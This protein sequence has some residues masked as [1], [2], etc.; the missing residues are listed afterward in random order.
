MEKKQKIVQQRI[1]IIAAVACV[2][3]LLASVL[4]LRYAIDENKRETQE[5][6]Q[7]VAQQS[8][9]AVD[10]Q[11][12]GDFQTLEGIAGI[13]GAMDNLD[14]EALLPVINDI[15][16]ENAFIRMGFTDRSGLTDGV[17][18]DG[19]VYKDIDL[20]DKGFVERAYAGEEV[21]TKTQWAETN[22]FWVNYYAVPIWHNGEVAKVLCAVNNSGAFSEI[23]DTSM[24]DGKGYAS[25]IDED[26]NYIIR[27]NHPSLDQD[28]D[29]LNLFELY[30]FSTEEKD[31]M[32]TDFEQG[33]SGFVEYT[34]RGIRMWASYTPLEVNGW[35]IFSVVPEAEINET[36]TMMTW[37]LVGIIVGAILV[38]VFLMVL[39]KRTNDKGIRALRKMAFTDQLT[40]YRNYPKFLIDVRKMLGRKRDKV[41]S[42]W[43]SDLKNF[44]TVNAMF[45]YDVGDR[46]LKFWAGLIESDMREGETFCRVSGD[47]FV[48]LREYISQEESLRRF[49]WIVSSLEAFPDTAKRGYKLEMCSG[50]YVIGEDD[51]DMTIND[52]MD[53]ANVAQKSVKN[54]SGARVA[55]YSAEMHKKIVREAEMEAR[56]ESALLNGEFQVYMQPKI[57]IQH[58][59]TIAGA[60]ALVR[61]ISPKDG[62]LAPGEFIPLFERNGFVIRLDEYMFESVCRMYRERLDGGLKMPV[63][64]SVNVSR[65]CMLQ[66]GFVERYIG[67]KNQYRIPDRCIE[68]EFTESIAF[69]NHALFRSIVKEFQENGF[70]CSLDDFGAGHS[71]LNILKDLPMDVLK[72]D[73][74][75]F[76]E[77]E[78]AHRARE[79]VKGIVNM[80]KALHMK[81]VAEGVES[82]EQVEFLRR[83]GCDV[84]QGYVFSK[85]LPIAE[86]D[87]FVALCEKREENQ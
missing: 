23:M 63:V 2:A 36:F 28:R 11:V 83:I 71:S 21:L 87:D 80:A 85:P 25:I 14:F 10:K 44:K 7:E 3:F 70:L 40:G 64:I 82:L 46:I 73:M 27:S 33:E 9:L 59:D 38:F 75:F 81:T 41:Y 57:D 67:I 20:K 42:L 62:F 24:F 6:M 54:L 45:G 19:T 74:L 65:L 86:F 8:K 1:Y 66:P 47:N 53:A 13:L 50:I 79:V 43:Y 49:H 17:D 55:F 61:W 26:G 4:F 77:G 12:Q 60:E 5:Y 48:V 51:G 78:N 16:Q 68:L 29:A 52:M 35:Y 58:G 30:P 39:I 15:N 34:H 84:V 18:I 72:I 32:R 76:R 22:D 31:R 37:G 56:M 69:D